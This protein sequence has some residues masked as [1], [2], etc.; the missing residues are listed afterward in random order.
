[1]KKRHQRKNDTVCEV[2][3]G[4]HRRACVLNHVQLFSDPMHCSLPG[5]PVHGIFPGKNAGV[6]CHFLLQGIFMTQGSILYLLRLLH[7]QVD[8]LPL[9]QKARS[10]L[11]PA[12][13]CPCYFICQGSSSISMIGHNSNILSMM[14]PAPTPPG[15]HL[16]DQPVLYSSWFTLFSSQRTISIKCQATDQINPACPMFLYNL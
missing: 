6:G 9:S 8:S 12:N 15:T 5:S 1:M 13:V 7:Q 14:P 3:T 11:L 4:N 2:N 10:S 16:S